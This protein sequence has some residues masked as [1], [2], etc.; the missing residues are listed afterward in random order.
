MDKQEFLASLRDG[1]F[2]EYG[3]VIKATLFRKFCDIEEIEKATR[4]EFE[5]Q[6]LQELSF[7]G[8]VKDHLLNHGKYFKKTGTSYRVLLPSENAD[9][10]LSYM[11]S[12]DSKL[13]RGIKLDKN[14][15]VEFK[16]H[17]NTHARLVMKQ[18]S[19]RKRIS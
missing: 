13:K 19:I 8:M 3:A 10:V 14:T 15:P 9:Q 11:K 2:F 17:D 5:A 7:S 1:G 4:Q 6:V 18:E 16:N 12:A